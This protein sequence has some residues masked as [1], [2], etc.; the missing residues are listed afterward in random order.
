MFAR[1]EQRISEKCRIFLS[2]LSNSIPHVFPPVFLRKSTR[3]EKFYV[4]RSEEQTTISAVTKL[5][6]NIARNR[7]NISQGEICKHRTRACRR[8]YVFIV[9]KYSKLSVEKLQITQTDVR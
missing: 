3:L 8:F 1:S 2:S 7:F 6:G 5:T 4:N 9:S